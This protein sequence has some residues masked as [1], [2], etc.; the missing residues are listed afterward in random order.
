MSTIA[1]L[2]INVIA[3]TRQL[4]RGL[5]EAGSAV[6]SFRQRIGRLSKGLAIMGLAGA[7]IGL[8]ALKRA[9]VAVMKTFAEFEHAVAEVKSILIDLT[10]KTIQP[11]IDQAKLLGE[12]TVFTA[13]EAAQAMAFLARAGFEVDEVM[14][15]VPSTLD[16]AAAGNLGLAEAADI[17][18]QVLRGMGLDAS[19]T[20]RVAD[21]LAL[22]SARTNTTVSQLG[23]AFAYAG[24]TAA[25]LGITLEETAAM[26]GMLSNAGIQADRSGTGLKNIMAELAAEIELNGIGAIKKF[27]EGGIGVGEAFKI[28]QKRGGPAILALEKMSD[29][30][31]TLT[32]EL[33]VA[34]GVVKEM[35]EKR[36]D[37]L[38]GSVI[39]LISKIKALAIEVGERFNK[40][41]REMV[42]GF[43]TFVKSLVEGFDEIV[44][45]K[46]NAAISQDTFAKS[47]G[48]VFVM[49]GEFTVFVSQLVAMFTY[50][51]RSVEQ[52]LLVV[53]TA[54]DTLISF[55][56]VVLSTTT[57][58]GDKINAAADNMAEH[59]KAS[60][61]G[62][63]ELA[64]KNQQDWKII[65][66]E[67]DA[68]GISLLRIGK[69]AQ[70]SVSDIP[71][72]EE[73][74]PFMLLPEGEMERVLKDE[75]AKIEQWHPP[76]LETELTFVLRMPEVKPQVDPEVVNA[77]SDATDD[78][79]D[80]IKAG[81]LT[82]STA[83]MDAHGKAIVEILAESN[84]LIIGGEDGLSQI[85]IDQAEIMAKRLKALDEELVLTKRLKDESD[86]LKESLKTPQVIFQET[87]DDLQKMRKRGLINI[88]QLLKGVALAREKMQ[89]DLDIG[90]DTGGV[91]GI[92]TALGAVKVAGFQNVAKDNLQANRDILGEEKLQ[93]VNLAA[94]I[95]LMRLN[96]GA[97]S[98]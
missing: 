65:R 15:A 23:H 26:L 19:E 9:F 25:A 92:Q 16:L 39:L 33:N 34:D 90:I 70:R 30:T 50:L 43:G 46:D 42:E 84:K 1:N 68:F 7:A 75:Y 47:L 13:H 98:P 64:E 4:R 85:L 37:S 72:K 38:T 95:G 93:N 28:F 54:V 29:R 52:L 62:F 78:L 91:E 18:A 63:S 66:G 14:K 31:R 77:I 3:N 81:E 35:A 6:G 41:L 59:W 40:T 53:I 36:M 22:T 71:K 57:F 76:K 45:V 21:V 2:K 86:R 69:A 17:T 67:A 82:I 5:K 88:P 61:L 27:T 51:A 24:P 49:I 83:G 55:L 8:Y 79:L 97:F 60:M 87:L 94:I 44:K 11:L 20:S 96:A 58:S 80:F 10:D 56:R 12:T 32:D 73:W 48:R 74:F 89:E